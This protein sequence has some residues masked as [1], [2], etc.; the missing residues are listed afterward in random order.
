LI[1]SRI[2]NILFALV[3]LAALVIALDPNS[4]RKAI[5]TVRSWEPEL[6]QLN[7]RVVINLPATST[8]AVGTTPIPTAT[9]IADADQD[10]QIPVTGDAENSNKP[11]I[12]VNWDVLAENL[13]QFWVSLSNVKIDLTPRDNK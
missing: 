6:R 2:V 10:E 13:K 1:L 12:Q 3:L 9:T 5:E 8:P 11:F 7:D 4:R